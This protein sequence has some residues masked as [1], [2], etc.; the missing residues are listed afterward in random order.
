MFRDIVMARETFIFKCLAIKKVIFTRRVS[1]QHII[2]EAKETNFFFQL[3][4]S[5]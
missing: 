4:I 3:S 2:S 1:N 5:F